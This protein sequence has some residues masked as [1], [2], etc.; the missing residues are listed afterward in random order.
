M[1]KFNSTNKPIS[2]ELKDILKKDAQKNF[3]FYSKKSL[4]LKEP[5]YKTKFLY[6]KIDNLNVLNFKLFQLFENNRPPFFGTLSKD[7]KLI[8]IP[9]KNPFYLNSVI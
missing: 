9:F 2:K 1:L 8:K 5:D 4:L 7:Q 6:K 3:L